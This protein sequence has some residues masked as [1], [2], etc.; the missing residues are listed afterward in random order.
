MR[1]ISF[2]CTFNSDLKKMGLK[3]KKVLETIFFQGVRGDKTINKTK[4]F[5]T[6]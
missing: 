6:L 5:F 2:A 1:L 4:I 3:N